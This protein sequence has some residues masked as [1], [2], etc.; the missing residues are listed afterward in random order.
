MPKCPE[1]PEGKQQELRPGEDV[2]PR[3]KNKKTGSR[4]QI[5]AGVAAA[6]VPIALTVFFKILAKVLAPKVPP[7]G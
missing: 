7:K 2:C 1:C 5:I 6:A 3:C 4:V